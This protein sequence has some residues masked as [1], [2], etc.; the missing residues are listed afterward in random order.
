MLWLRLDSAP[1]QVRPILPLSWPN[2]PSTRLEAH[3][4]AEQARR[5]AG[6]VQ[7]LAEKKK[8][9]EADDWTV[10]DIRRTAF[11][12]L[13]EGLQVARQAR[14]TG[15]EAVCKQIDELFD[16]SAIEDSTSVF[17]DRKIN[18]TGEVS[19]EFVRHNTFEELNINLKPAQLHE[20]QRK[21][22]SGRRRMFNQ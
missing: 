10:N 4:Q 12:I 13:N 6:R 7:R 20:Y 2:K 8:H 3:R 15:V 14:Q 19:A 11:S 22:I 5:A 16:W 9:H 21:S 1:S 18:L 17:R